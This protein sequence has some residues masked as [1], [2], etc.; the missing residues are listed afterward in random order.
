MLLRKSIFCGIYEVLNAYRL[1]SLEGMIAI[2]TD[3][4][5]LPLWFLVLT[6]IQFHPLSSNL[7]FKISPSLFKF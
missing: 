3:A 6:G 4:L 2:V 7:S 5:Q 1:W